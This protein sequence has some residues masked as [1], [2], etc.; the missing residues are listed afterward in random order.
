[1]DYTRSSLKYLHRLLRYT[2][3]LLAPLMKYLSF[4]VFKIN[5]PWLIWIKLSWSICLWKTPFIELLIPNNYFKLVMTIASPSPVTVSE[6]DIWPNSGQW[7][8]R[9]SCWE[10]WVEISLMLRRIKE[11]RVPMFVLCW[12]L[13]RGEVWNHC[14]Q[15]A[16]GSKA[17]PAHGKGTEAKTR[18]PPLDISS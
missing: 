15:L 13:S 17:K 18:L 9:G 14:K 5:T 10:A 2:K 7:G 16:C 4:I 1:M 12:C 3:S 8:V 11:N 6:M